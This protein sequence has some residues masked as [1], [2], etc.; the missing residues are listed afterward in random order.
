VEG[1]CFFQDYRLY[2]IPFPLSLGERVIKRT[3]LE[4]FTKADALDC[5]GGSFGSTPPN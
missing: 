2:F 5:G 4:I 3:R 1:F